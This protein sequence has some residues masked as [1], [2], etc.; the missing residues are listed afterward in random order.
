MA[1]IAEPRRAPTNR[2]NAVTW[3]SPQRAVVARR[4]PDG[5]ISLLRLERRLPVE[6]EEQFLVRVSL[7][8]GPARRVMVLGPVL[9]RVRFERVDV[10]IHGRPERLVDGPG[11][12]LEAPSLAELE[13]LLETGA[14]RP[15]GAGRR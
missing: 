8:V 4:R 6:D 3:V 10:A 14:L 5:T 12:T 1:A 15:V 2:A 7:D 9:D 13:P 11:D